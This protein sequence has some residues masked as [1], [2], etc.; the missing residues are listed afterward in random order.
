[1]LRQYA[2]TGDMIARA[3]EINPQD[4]EVLVNKVKHL[5]I[6][7][8][9]PA[10]RAVLER[11]LPDSVGGQ[12]ESLLFVQLLRGTAFRRGRP[13]D[14]NP[15]RQREI[16]VVGGRHKFPGAFGRRPSLGGYKEAARRAYLAAKRGFATL[17]QEQPESPFFTANLLRQKRDL[18]TKRPRCARRDGRSRSCR[19]QK[20]PVLSRPWKKPSRASR[21][22]WAKASARS[23]GSS[24]FFFFYE[25][26]QPLHRTETP[27]RLRMAGLY[28]VGAWLLV[29]VAGR[30]CRSSTRRPGS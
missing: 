18:G 24:F 27:Q 3:L 26:A 21:R 10:A 19:P 13:A 25:P 6:I 1:M 2:A 14:G 23:R 28:L 30:C 5:Q 29:Q 8:D 7:G 15:N 16:R 12:T 17:R 4:P 9:L 22:R 20:I 11:L